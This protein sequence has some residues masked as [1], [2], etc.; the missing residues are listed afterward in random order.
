M[1]NNNKQTSKVFLH[2]RKKGKNMEKSKKTLAL[3]LGLIMAVTMLAGLSAGAEDTGT[4]KITAPAGLSLE[5]QTYDAYRICAVKQSGDK[6][7]YTLLSPFDTFTNYPGS[8]TTS[9]IK[10]ISGLTDDSAEMDALA[11][12]LWGFIYNNG[13]YGKATPYS[14]TGAT[15]ATEVVI[16]GIPLGYYLV[17]GAGGANSGNVVSACALVTTKPGAEIVLKADVPIIDKYVWNHHDDISDWIK[18]TD[19]NMGYTPTFRIDTGVPIMRSYDRYRF[20]VHDMLSPG[21]TFIPT[22]LEVWI[23]GMSSWDPKRGSATAGTEYNEYQ[24]VFPTTAHDDHVGPC[25]CTFMVVFDP[26]EFI[27][28]TPGT[29]IYIYYSATLNSN[30]VIEWPG[31]PNDVRLEYSSNPHS[32]ATNFTRWS[33]VKVYTGLLGLI[34][35]DGEDSDPLAGAKFE[36]WTDPENE[37]SALW[38]VPVPNST[39]ANYN[40]MNSQIGGITWLTYAKFSSMAIYKVANANTANA[41]KVLTTPASGEILIL[42]LA[43]SYAENGTAFDSFGNYWFIETEAPEGYYPIEDP[44]PV[45]L[46]IFSSYIGQ[47]LNVDDTTNWKIKYDTVT[48]DDRIV[49]V[50]LAS[51]HFMPVPNSGTPEFPSTGGIGRKIFIVGGIALMSTALVSLIVVSTSRKRKA[52][53]ER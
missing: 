44:I 18:W 22:S 21:L 12:A 17:Y 39:T 53:S 52:I 4:I 37:S 6:F 19:G 2:Q 30:A 47:L 29:E 40:S 28:L 15:G 34:K 35:V 1:V 46:Q 16:S 26:D 7:A 38:F 20:T 11:K 45:Q 32:S 25:Y 27:K 49:P 10:Y 43:A 41:T 50:Q 8:D 23:G 24:L 3:I 36:V 14:A 42:G 51:S 5:G 48:T 13:Q 31:N 9:L 33:K